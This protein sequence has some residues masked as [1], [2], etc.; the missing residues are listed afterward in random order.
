MQSNYVIHCLTVMS[1][2]LKAMFWRWDKNENTLWDIATFK[3]LLTMV[4]ATS[5]TGVIKINS[6]LI[7]N[8]KCKKMPHCSRQDDTKM[9]FVWSNAHFVLLDKYT[10]HR[11]GRNCPFSLQ[12]PKIWISPNKFELNLVAKNLRG[13]LPSYPLIQTALIRNS[14]AYFPR[15]R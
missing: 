9:R 5:R 11:T 8:L 13:L 12:L 3:K 14:N 4:W 2:R 15:N 10:R 1:M 6:Y 7:R